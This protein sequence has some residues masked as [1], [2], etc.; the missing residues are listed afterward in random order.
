[1]I[2]PIHV[3]TLSSKV[4]LQPTVLEPGR[5][6]IHAACQSGVSEQIILDQ[7]LALLMAQV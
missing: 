3:C 6:D 4:I 7:W 5:G 1:M 2:C